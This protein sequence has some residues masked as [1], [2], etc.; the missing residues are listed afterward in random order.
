MKTNCTT[1]P[2]SNLTKFSK[3]NLIELKNIKGGTGDDGT[4]IDTVDPSAPV[5]TNNRGSFAVSGKSAS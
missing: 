3:M 1:K 2:E 4:P 5:E